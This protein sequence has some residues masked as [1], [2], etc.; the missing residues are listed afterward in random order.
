MI[1]EKDETL[2]NMKCT[3]K[4]L[5]PTHSLIKWPNQTWQ[6]GEIHFGQAEN[7]SAPLISIF[8]FSYFSF[9]SG[10]KVLVYSLIICDSFLWPNIQG[11]PSFVDDWI[12]TLGE[13]GNYH[14]KHLT[15][16]LLPWHFNLSKNLFMRKPKIIVKLNNLVWTRTL[17]K[18]ESSTCQDRQ[19]L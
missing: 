9:P 11:T 8:H 7:F 3:G 12:D 4:V 18:N 10:C 6:F 2:D 16:S 14:K 13:I 17:N 19:W 15:S 5:G 1:T